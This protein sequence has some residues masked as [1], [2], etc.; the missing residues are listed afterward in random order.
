MSND[1]DENETRHGEVYGE[2][3]LGNVDAT[4]KTGGHIHHPIAPCK[5]P[6][7]KISHRRHLSLGSI[8]PRN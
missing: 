4:D 3:F 5:A 6:R 2:P 7:A 1:R 8:Q